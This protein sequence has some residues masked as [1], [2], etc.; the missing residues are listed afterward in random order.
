MSYTDFTEMPVWQ[1]ALDLLLQIYSTTKAFP[2]TERF[3]L[4]SDM[5]RSANSITH[6]IAE[7]FG[8]FEPR[9]KTRFYK[10]SRGS[11]YELMSQILVSAALS[12]LP[13]QAKA[14]LINQSKS[15]IKELNAIIKTLESQSSPQPQPQP[16]P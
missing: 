14:N 1:L 10:I 12:Y 13:E 4:V 7:G 2:S 9:D 16:Q 15:I 6:N 11:A 3:G 8:R 5:R